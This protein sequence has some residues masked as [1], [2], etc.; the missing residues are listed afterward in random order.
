MAGIRGS[1]K[2]PS[3]DETKTIVM[4]ADC[5]G[6]SQTDFAEF[7]VIMAPSDPGTITKPRKSFRSGS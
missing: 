6:D 2:D 7:A 1:G 5:D 3:S 4:L